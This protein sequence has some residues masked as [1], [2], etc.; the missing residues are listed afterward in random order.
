MLVSFFGA[1]KFIPRMQ[2]VEAH[3]INLDQGNRNVK[4]TNEDIGIF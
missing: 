2:V 4:C 3:R 1:L